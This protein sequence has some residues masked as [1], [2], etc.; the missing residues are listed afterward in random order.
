M[1]LGK[2]VCDGC[3]GRSF[4]KKGDSYECEYCGSSYIIENDENVVSKTLTDAQI[5]EYY[6]EATKYM[7]A[8]N[9]SEEFK[10]LSKALDLA[11]NNALTLV[12]LGRCYRNLG[13][14]DKAIEAYQKALE[15]D[16]SLGTAYTNLGTIYILNQ[17]W[18]E[19]ATQYQMGLP[20]IDQKE[21]D[22]WTAYANYAIAVAKLGDTARANNMIKEAEQHGYKNGNTCRSLAGIKAQGCYVA[23]CVYGSYDCPQVWTLRRYRDD[24]LGSTWYGRLFIRAYYAISPTLVK[25]FGN[26]TWFKK[27]WEVKLDRMVAKLQAEGVKDTPY[28]D[29]NW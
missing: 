2:I 5:I 14:Q 8:N 10:A 17:K 13:L 12:K 19:A 25:W 4:I 20:L 26:T 18:S 28:E 11:P 7:L 22:Y 27:F 16:P 1:E 3:G 9:Y 23:T 15:I 21:D 24:T 29:K 6:L